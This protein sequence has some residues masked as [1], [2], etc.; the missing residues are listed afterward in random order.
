MYLW[1]CRKRNRK[2]ASIRTAACVLSFYRENNL[3]N[4]DETTIAIY[5]NSFNLLLLVQSI[6]RTV[7]ANQ[8]KAVLLNSRISA[9]LY[10]MHTETHT[11]Y[12]KAIYLI[13]T[14]LKSQHFI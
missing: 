5:F 4:H 12:T 14:S 7:K 9:F 10:Y 2:D 13:V 8:S 11:R 6:A 1:N 3:I